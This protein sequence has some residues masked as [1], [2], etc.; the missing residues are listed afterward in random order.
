MSKYI[1]I[2]YVHDKNLVIKQINN[3]IKSKIPNLTFI[4]LLDSYEYIH[5]F[6]NYGTGHLS[7]LTLKI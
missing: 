1:V 2:I 5:F 4:V 3:L 6:S 7:Y